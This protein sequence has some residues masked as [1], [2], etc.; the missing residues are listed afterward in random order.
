MPTLVCC[1]F[2]STIVGLFASIINDILQ[3]YRY[4]ARTLYVCQSFL[5]RSY[6]QTDYYYCF[7]VEKRNVYGSLS[8][9]SP[10]TLSVKTTVFKSMLGGFSSHSFW[11]IPSL[12]LSTITYA[13]NFIHRRWRRYA[14]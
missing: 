7:E 3:T 8:I 14:I 11:S 4:F 12:S 13:A 6:A 9:V 5:S 2:D 1:N 10:F